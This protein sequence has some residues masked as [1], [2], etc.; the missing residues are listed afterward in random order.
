ML[1]RNQGLLLKQVQLV[2]G[3]S[4][5]LVWK[6]RVP[7][8]AYSE[9]HYLRTQVSTVLISILLRWWWMLISLSIRH[10]FCMCNTQILEGFKIFQILCKYTWSIVSNSDML[11]LLCCH[12]Q[13]TWTIKYFQSFF[14]GKN[15]IKI[16]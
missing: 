12:W 16:R 2:T 10:K 8:Y 13:C 3:R 11:R 9:Q 6:L 1:T 4:P 7:L 5:A 15:Y 14:Q